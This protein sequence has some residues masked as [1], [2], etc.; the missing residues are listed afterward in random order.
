MSALLRPGFRREEL[1]SRYAVS[2]FIEDDWHTY[3]GEQTA[4]IVSDHLKTPHSNSRWLLNAGSGIYELPL[5]SWSVVSIDLFFEPIRNRQ[6]SICA[7]VEH[8][9]FAAAT[10]GGIVCVGEVLGYCDPAKAI[11]EFARILAPSGKLLLD[12]GSTFSSRHWFS[13]S[14]GRAADQ[15]VVPY[16]GSMER[17]WNYSPAYLAS[18]LHSYG[19]EITNQIGLNGWSA[20][21]QRLGVSVHSALRIERTLSQILLPKRWADIMTVVAERAR[22]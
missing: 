11:P 19:F 10:F 18:L 12:F 17:I 5:E 2:S 8:L 15:T 16:N 20:L 4:K 3:C 21:L 9:P 7:S 14:Y 13:H 1:R 22:A 6:L